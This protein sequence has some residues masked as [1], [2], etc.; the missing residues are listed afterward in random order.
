MA[1]LDDILKGTIGEFWPFEKRLRRDQDS[2][3]DGYLFQEQNSL[4]VDAVDHRTTLERFGEET[5]PQCPDHL[6]G[7]TAYGGVLLTNS[8]GRGSSS[9]FGGSKASRYNFRYKSIISGV[10]IDD[11][12]SA[13]VYAIL[14]TFP[15]GLSWGQIPAMTVQF[16]RH[17]G[18]KLKSATIQVGVDHQPSIGRLNGGL[19][20]EISPQWSVS[21]PDEDKRVR[22]A[23]G[24]EVRSTRPRSISELIAPIIEI[25][26]LISVANGIHAHCSEGKVTP[27]LDG[28][29]EKK[30]KIWDR[31]L[32]REPKLDE[33][34][35]FAGPKFTLPDLGGVP[36]VRRWLQLVDSNPRFM[37]PVT[38]RWQLGRPAVETRI[39]DLHSAIEQYVAA[40]RQRKEGWAKQP[41]TNVA[42]VTFARHCPTAFKKWVG[43]V[44]KWGKELQE[45]N[46]LIKH[47]PRSADPQRMYYVGESAEIAI[48]S[49][50]LRFASRRTVAGRNYIENPNHNDLGV[51]VRRLLT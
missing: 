8:T 39:L 12:L 49:V 45:L 30:P 28:D 51:E 10:R 40:S 1:D 21:G 41:D 27:K 47:N 9:T 24:V 23:L 2:S 3:F 37:R 48:V 4:R 25:Q 18:G 31:D 15:D 50:A 19:K 17:D 6:I 13:N 32:F 22:T 46:N 11:L 38:L 14:A 44:E 33:K 43:D 16:G 34:P 35:R 42:A 5:T 29:L 26:Q 20:L 7:S 36:G